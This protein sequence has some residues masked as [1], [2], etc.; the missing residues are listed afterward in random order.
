MLD[1]PWDACS[2]FTQERLITVAQFIAEVR[3]EVIDLHDDSL[4]DTPLALG[5][6]AYECCRTRLIREASRGTYPWLSILTPEK[7]F[8]LKIG[9]TPV[10]FSRNDP[11]YLPDR[12]LIASPEAARQMELFSDKRDYAR[13]RWFFVFDTSCDNAAD[14][15]Y[16][17]GYAPSG[18]IICQWQIPIEDPVT[19]VYV[20]DSGTSEPVEIPRAPI[21]VKRPSLDTGKNNSDERDAP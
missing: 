15:V 19:A 6:R 8:T 2:D 12:K 5:I 21:G 10:R 17:V 7:R 13:V 18:E 4:G 14:A 16:F 11:D 3:A 1:S 9:A 20:L